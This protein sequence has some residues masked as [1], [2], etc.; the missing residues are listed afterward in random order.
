MLLSDFTSV[1]AIASKAELL[2]EVVRFA[3]RLG[4]DIVNAMVVVDGLSNDPQFIAVHNTPAAYLDRF[5][6]LSVA[7]LDPVMQ[8]CKRTNVPIVWTQDTYIG[9]DRGEMW[10][11]QAP[12]GYRTGIAFALHLPR[13]RHFVI[14]VDR[15]QPLPLCAKELTR[16]VAEL[17]LFGVQAQEAALRVLLREPLMNGLPQ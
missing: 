3:R 7:R 16:M 12:F 14:G 11:E 8:H 4:F 13:G 2:E 6:D 10:E 15:D 1:Q 9:A 5:E 17:Q